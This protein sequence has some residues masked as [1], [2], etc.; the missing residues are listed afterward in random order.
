MR[1]FA[2]K[3]L[4][5]DLE[6]DDVVQEAFI[7]GWRRLGEI[8]DPANVR[9][10]LMRIVSNRA[11]DRMR[12]RKVHEPLGDHEPRG[13][14]SDDPGRIVETRMQLDAVWIALD[15]L[16]TVQRRCWLLRETAGYSYIEI[17]DALEIPV[18]T[19]RGM[20]ARTR[21]FLLHELEAWR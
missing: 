17:A 11:I 8:D 9:S 20:L 6:S 5:S 3:L 1:V 7:T 16:P 13:R 10:W 12:V 4:G 2:A 15:E 14:A 21:T 18:T 19:V